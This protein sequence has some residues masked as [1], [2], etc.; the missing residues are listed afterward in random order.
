MRACDKCACAGGRRGI[1]GGHGGGPGMLSELWREV[2]L[3]II[4]EC[5]CFDGVFDLVHYVV[6][7][8]GHL[9]VTQ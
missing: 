7:W 5:V 1:W 8:C 6:V 3:E 9:M 4:Q 2:C